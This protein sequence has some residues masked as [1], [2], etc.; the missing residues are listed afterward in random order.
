VEIDGSR[1]SAIAKAEARIVFSTLREK[2]ARYFQRVLAISIGSLAISYLIFTHPQGRRQSLERRLGAAKATSEYA[3][4]Y[5][6]IHT[7]LL[8]LYRNLPALKDR[9]GLLLNALVDS[10]KAESIT[11]DALK[12]AN[13]EETG[14]LIYQSV[15]MS[16]TIPFSEF[17]S[18]L[19]R[20]ENAKPSMQV[21]QM[22]LTKRSDPIGVNAVA[23]T[24]YTI[25]PKGRF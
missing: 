12:P 17:V 14:N 15:T 23:C 8:A 7:Q 21:T 13:E 6:E 20:I 18:W 22:S 3:D 10:L 16:S 11:P 4:Q 1:L 19:S 24:I 25:I 2:G 9:D 5:K